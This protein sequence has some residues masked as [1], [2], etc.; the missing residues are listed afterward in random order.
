MANPSKNIT[1]VSVMPSSFRRNLNF[2]KIKVVSS[3]IMIPMIQDPKI[4]TIKFKIISKLVY[5]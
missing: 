2:L 3:P 4:R 1:V 5:Q